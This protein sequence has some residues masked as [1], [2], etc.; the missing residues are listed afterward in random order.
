MDATIKQILSGF[1]LGL[2]AYKEKL[3]ESNV[4]L[5]KA[6]GIFGK[7]AD[8]AGAAKDMMD[9]YARP[10]VTTLMA[11]LSAVMPE[12]AKEKTVQGV[13]TVPSAASAAAGYHLAYGQIPKDQVK[14]RSIYERIFDIEKNSENAM[15]FTRK[16]AEEGLY[17]TMSTTPI[18]EKQ[19]GLLENAKNLSLP[20]MNYHEKMKT[21]ISPAQSI[22]ELEY[23]SNLEAEV[24]IYQN[25]WDTALLNTSSTLLGN[26]ISGWMLTQSED[27]RQEVENSCRFIA[28]F[29]G[30]DFEG[31]YNIPRI[32][33]HFDK[34]IFGPMKKDLAAK[35]IDT[36]EKM[37]ASLKAV[38]DACLKGKE[39]VKLGPEA[40]RS[41]ILWG[42]RTDIKDLE[43][44]YRI[45]FDRKSNLMPI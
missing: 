29:Y 7:L 32:R 18:L 28:E 17:V 31:L 43:Q 27:D 36:P 6:L 2:D 3:G 11:D 22:A 14:T 24:S 10:E 35:G 44:A 45:N 19:D 23:V 21:R 34:V 13:R 15:V 38:V 25:L 42:V 8:L 41:L 16:M 12:L 33:D 20:M 1:E 9:F 26:A 40:N 30:L 39:T 5:K 37:L 4:T